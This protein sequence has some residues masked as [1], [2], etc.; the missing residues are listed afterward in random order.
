MP[1]MNSCS[2]KDSGGM[3]SL[4][5]EIPSKRLS[6]QAQ[7]RDADMGTLFWAG[8]FAQRTRRS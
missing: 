8:V 6:D 7:A 3:C 5:T 1:P 2:P 4:S